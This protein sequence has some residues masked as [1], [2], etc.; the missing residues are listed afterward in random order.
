ME[1]LD[2][3]ESQKL[4][5]THTVIEWIVVFVSK[6]KTLYDEWYKWLLS[7][8]MASFNGE[9]FAST[10]IEPQAVCSSRWHVRSVEDSAHDFFFFFFK[11]LRRR[12]MQ[13]GVGV[14]FDSR[15]QVIKY[16]HVIKFTKF[17][18]YV[19]DIYIFL[20]RMIK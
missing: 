14:H 16:Q 15:T 3:A 1:S 2:I 13:R 10:D 6:T 20:M 17:K 12:L 8:C 4:G 5:W 18:F 19:L 7:C 9:Q 11:E